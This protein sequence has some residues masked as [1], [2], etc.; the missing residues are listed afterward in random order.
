R[1]DAMTR[2]QIAGQ[3]L[4]GEK[5]N[6]IEQLK[7]QHGVE[8]AFFS[9]EIGGISNEDLNKSPNEVVER[10]MAQKIVGGFTDLR[11][12]LQR[13]TERTGPDAAKILGVVILT[14]GQHDWGPLPAAKAGEL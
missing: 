5:I 8:F 14:D 2:F 3:V 7:K 10:L 11:L 12:P 6:L 1:I 9:Q 4:H 13:A